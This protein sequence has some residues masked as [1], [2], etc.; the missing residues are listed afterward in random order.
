MK[1]GDRVLV[2]SVIPGVPSQE[3]IY[4]GEQKLD[5]EGKEITSLYN[6]TKDV[7]GHPTGST[8]S[9][10]TLEDELGYILPTEK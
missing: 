3:I 7:T 4:I 2:H 1:R 8:V 6:L 5:L 10:I 9:S